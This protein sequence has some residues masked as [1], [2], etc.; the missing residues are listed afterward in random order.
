MNH[1]D[2]MW[3]TGLALLAASAMICHALWLFYEAWR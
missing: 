3:A 1:D 2:F